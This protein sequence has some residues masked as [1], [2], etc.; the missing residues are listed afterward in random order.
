MAS[1]SSSCDGKASWSQPNDGASNV[2]QM[3][4]IEPVKENLQPLRVGRSV[5]ALQTFIAAADATPRHN[6]GR[7]HI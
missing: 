3:S 6:D 4:S 2:I 7:Q 1:L 5:A